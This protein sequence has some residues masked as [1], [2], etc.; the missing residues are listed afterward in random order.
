M[1]SMIYMGSSKNQKGS[2]RIWRSVVYA[3]SKRKGLRNSPLTLICEPLK[4]RQWSGA[5]HWK[6]RLLCVRPFT[7]LPFA[8]PI[9]I[10]RQYF[11]FYFCFIFFKP[12][13]A[14]VYIFKIYPLSSRSFS[15]SQLKVIPKLRPLCT[16]KERHL[17]F[18]RYEKSSC[19]KPRPSPISL[20]TP[21]QPSCGT[22]RP[23]KISSAI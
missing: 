2:L 10:F 22:A 18:K 3:F 8:P 17:T 9:R 4:K 7:R 15:D 6:P 12:H 13:K 21:A 16:L 14:S 20:G 5:N 1:S 23:S 11:V 19:V